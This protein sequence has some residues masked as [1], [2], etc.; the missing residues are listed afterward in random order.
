[1][2]GPRHSPFLSLQR[3][4]LPE[5][6]AGGG[7]RSLLFGYAGRGIFAAEQCVLPSFDAVLSIARVGGQTAAFAIRMPSTT[8]L[9]WQS[10]GL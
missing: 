3:S 6:R 7:G 10:T 9:V 2:R 5:A 1:M 4:G 8:G